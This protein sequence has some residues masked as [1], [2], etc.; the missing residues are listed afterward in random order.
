[1]TIERLTRSDYR[2]DEECNNVV[3]V[4]RLVELFDELKKRR[5]AINSNRGYRMD[6]KNYID[7]DFDDDI[8]EHVDWKDI[9]ELFGPLV[10]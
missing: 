10:K 4:E 7:K 3:L 2:Y 6:Y 5:F 1:M 9:E 8:W